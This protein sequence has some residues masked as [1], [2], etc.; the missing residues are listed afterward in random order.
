[1]HEPESPSRVLSPIPLLSASLA[2]INFSL[3][4]VYQRHNCQAGRANLSTVSCNKG[5]RLQHQKHTMHVHVHVLKQLMTEVLAL[6][7]VT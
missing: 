2:S 6:T 4:V 7:G 5:E 1:L 3:P